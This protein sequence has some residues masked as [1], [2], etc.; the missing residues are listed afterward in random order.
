M[1]GR[2][3]AHRTVV[4]GYSAPMTT[5]PMEPHEEPREEVA[6][7]PGQETPDTAPGSGDEGVAPGDSPER[8]AEEGEP[9]EPPD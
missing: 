6:A 1:D 3:T 2:L 8:A 5:S 9:V 4:A 7:D